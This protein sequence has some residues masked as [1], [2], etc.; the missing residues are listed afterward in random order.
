MAKPTKRGGRTTPKKA[1]ASGRY[2]PPVPR[3]KKVSPIWV[4][5]LMFT[6]LLVGVAL[7]VINYLGVLPGGTKNLYL[8]IGLGLITAGLLTAT[9]YR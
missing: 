3:K 6:C 8:L 9:Q 4:P 7:I 5:A 2:T 1:V